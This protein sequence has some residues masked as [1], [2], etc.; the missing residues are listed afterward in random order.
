ME[1]GDNGGRKRAG[2]NNPFSLNLMDVHF[3]A[4]L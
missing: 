4:D 3:I 1:S 2:Q